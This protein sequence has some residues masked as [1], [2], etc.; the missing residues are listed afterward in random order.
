M[1]YLMFDSICIYLFSW[2]VASLERE[3]GL[4]KYFA[5]TIGGLSLIQLQYLVSL[6]AIILFFVLLFGIRN[7]ASLVTNKDLLQK[8]ILI[9]LGCGTVQFIMVC[10]VWYV[11]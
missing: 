11:W 9:L 6:P 5:N 1:L 7:W 8:L 3:W 4:M 10:T 2:D